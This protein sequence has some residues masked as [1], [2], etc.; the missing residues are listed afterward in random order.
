MHTSLNIVAV[1]RVCL[2]MTEFLFV[3]PTQKWHIGEELVGIVHVSSVVIYPHLEPMLSSKRCPDFEEELVG[4]ER[5]GLHHIHFPTYRLC[6][7]NSH[8]SSEESR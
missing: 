3:V 7:K 5:F 2:Q 4:R 6:L 1:V 8:Q